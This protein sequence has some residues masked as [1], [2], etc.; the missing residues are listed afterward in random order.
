ME[1]VPSKIDNLNVSFT[2]IEQEKPVEV[3]IADPPIANIPAN[4]SKV[5]K[6]WTRKDDAEWERGKSATPE[7]ERKRRYESRHR[8]QSRHGKSMSKEKR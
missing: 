2:E 6:H 5:S 4:D 7:K 1:N 3:I 8:D